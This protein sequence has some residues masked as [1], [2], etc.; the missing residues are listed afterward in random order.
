MLATFETGTEGWSSTSLVGGPWSTT[1]WSS[2]GSRSL[3]GDITMSAGSTH[4]LF[5]S[6]N[7]NFTGNTKLRATVKGASWGNYGSGLGVKLYV[8]H[9]SSYTWK[10]SG[11]ATITAGGLVNLTLDLSGV[12]LADIREY[13]IQFYGGSNASGTTAVYVDNVVLGN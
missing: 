13:G 10:D 9:G 5:K 12:N 11:S 6:G 1:A 4:Y 7:T 3:Q 2:Q 8:K